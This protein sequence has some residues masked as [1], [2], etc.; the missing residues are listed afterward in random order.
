MS[1]VRF[2]SDTKELLKVDESGVFVFTDKD[3]PLSLSL[4]NV[5]PST[6]LSAESDNSFNARVAR[7]P[8]FTLDGENIVKLSEEGVVTA[9][10]KLLEAVFSANIFGE[11]TRLK[12]HDDPRTSQ[13]ARSR[14][15]ESGVA[16][17]LPNDSS[18]VLILRETYWQSMLAPQW[19]IPPSS[20]GFPLVYTYSAE[21]RRHPLRAPKPAPG[22][23]IYKRFIPHLG[24]NL[25]LRVVDPE[26]EQDVQMFS[27]WQNSPRVAAA[28]KQTGSLEE[29]QAYLKKQTEDKHQI[30]VIGSFDEN[31]CLYA[32]L[33][34][35]QEDSLAPHL[36]NSGP[37]DRGFHILVGSESHRGPQ[38]VQA[39]ASSIVHALFLADPRTMRIVME[40]RLSN[41]KII[42]YMGSSVGF[43]VTKHFDFPHKRSALLELSRERFFQLAP[44]HYQS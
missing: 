20:F 1:P 9:L 2:N 40:P 11:W 17:A 22:T 24:E 44:F 7:T 41:T 34:W 31:D 35:L 26:N 37:F 6:D 12:F 10:K 29:H 30:P 42:D 8:C 4:R 25:T 36:D 18:S 43:V 19:Y 27:T 21:G 16:L 14:L 15:L 3:T 38:R 39:W 23:I 28:W 33:Y 5:L 13:L 32:E